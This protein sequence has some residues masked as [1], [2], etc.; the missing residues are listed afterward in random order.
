M[1]LGKEVIILVK[2]A[3]FADIF[4]KKLAEVLSERI[5]IHKQAIQLEDGKQPP[6]RPIYSLSLVELKTLKIYIETN[7]ANGFI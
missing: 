3:D 5:G 2:Y 6:Y 4:S 1:L 7:L